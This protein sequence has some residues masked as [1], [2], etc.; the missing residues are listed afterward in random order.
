MKIL[1]LRKMCC[2]FEVT[3]LYFNK[4]KELLSI[5]RNI[6]EVKYDVRLCPIN[7]NNNVKFDVR[8]YPIVSSKFQL[9]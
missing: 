1:S 4:F 7:P 6:N 9:V 3:R 2:K 8:L 5:V